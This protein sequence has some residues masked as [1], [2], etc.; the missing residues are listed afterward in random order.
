MTTATA[1]LTILYTTRPK[2]TLEF[3]EAAFGLKRRFFNENPGYGELEVGS[4]TL[5]ISNIVLEQS[6]YPAARASTVDDPTFGFHVS[7]QTDDAKALFD[8][9]AR[10]GATVIHELQKLPWGGTV[11]RLKDINGVLVSIISR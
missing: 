5:A 9:A 7:F 4:T 11:A 3:Y 8:Q 10:Q 2:E 1:T 6:E